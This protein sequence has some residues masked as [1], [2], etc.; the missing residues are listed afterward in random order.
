M[1]KLEAC[2]SMAQGGDLFLCGDPRV[3]RGV[4]AGALVVSAGFI[5]VG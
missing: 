5:T 2:W 1:A 3:H 4:V